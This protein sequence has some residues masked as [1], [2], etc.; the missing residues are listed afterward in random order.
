MA[1]G[2][3]EDMRQL[4]VEKIPPAAILFAEGHAFEPVVL[5]LPGRVENILRYIAATCRSV[6]KHPMIIRVEN[7][8]ALEY[9]T[10]VGQWTKNPRDEICFLATR[11]ALIA[12]K[13]EVRGKF[14][15]VGHFPATGQF[16]TLDHRRGTA[17]PDDGG[18]SSG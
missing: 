2:D 8:D 11:T 9:L 4:P 7:N 3:P 12:A 15:T 6:L 14:S 16:I 10:S 5:D 13:Q 1:G 17:V 18:K